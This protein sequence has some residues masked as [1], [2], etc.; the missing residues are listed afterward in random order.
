MFLCICSAIDQN[1]VRTKK[2]HTRQSQVIY[3]FTD[4]W[5][6]GI[7]LFHIIKMY[8]TGRIVNGD[9]IHASVSSN[10][11]WL[12]KPHVYFM[13]NDILHKAKQHMVMSLSAFIIF[14]LKLYLPFR[15][16]SWTVISPTSSQSLYVNMKLLV[17]ACLEATT[18]RLII[19]QYSCSCKAV[20]V[21]F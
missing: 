7:H 4:P 17:Y 21:V 5:Q 3:Y 15:R 13:W 14:F 18:T 6:C 9:F 1:E 11:S 10:R 20:C 12:C 2:W 8:H 19:L 16:L